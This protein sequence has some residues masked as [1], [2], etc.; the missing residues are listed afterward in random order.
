M[1]IGESVLKQKQTES[2][3]RLSK[4]EIKELQEYQE[5]MRELAEQ[6]RT[7]AEGETEKVQV[8]K[9]M[10][11]SGNV[12]AKDDHYKEVATAQERL[13]GTQPQCE[14]ETEAVLKVKKLK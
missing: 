2:P 6:R 12:E 9:E 14:S 7:E 4:A 10:V 1:G 13:S 8:Q 3:P 11:P 5:R